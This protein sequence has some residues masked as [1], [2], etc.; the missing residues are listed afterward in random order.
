VGVVASGFADRAMR[1]VF[2][3]R[4]ELDFVAY[5]LMTPALLAITILAAFVPARRASRVDPMQALR[6]E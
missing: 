4:T 1:A 2:P 6:Y 5:L 3:A